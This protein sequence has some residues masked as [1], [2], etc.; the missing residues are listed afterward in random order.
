MLQSYGEVQFVTE[1][2][3]GSILPSL[4]LVFVFTHFAAGLD[5]ERSHWVKKKT[6]KK[7]ANERLTENFS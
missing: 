2:E 5:E 3:T 6:T 4:V 7:A 1:S